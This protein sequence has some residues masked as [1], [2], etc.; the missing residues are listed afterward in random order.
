MERDV[1]IAKLLFCL[2][3]TGDATVDIIKQYIS[4]QGEKNGKQ[5]N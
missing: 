5:G 3:T 4:T 2:L 1:L